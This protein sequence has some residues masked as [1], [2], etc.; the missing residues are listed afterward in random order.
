M[1]DRLV[2]KV[3]SNVLTRKDGSI[4]VTRMSSLTDQIAS[5]TENGKEIIL[6]SSGSVACGRSMVEV[7][8]K[9]DSVDQRQLYSAV[10]QVRL[11]N[12]YY[13]LFR[14]HG[15]RI[16]QVLTMKE[17]FSTRREYLNQKNCMEV[18]LKS[19][20]LPVVNENDTVS[21]TELMFTDNDELSSLVASMMDAKTL[22]ILSNVDGIFDGS[23]AEPG[24]K[25]ISE[26]LPDSD[27]SRYIKE[28]KSSLGRGGM[29]SKFT[30]ARNAAL[31]GIKVI[32]ANGKR[33]NILTDLFTCPEN[34]PHTTFMPAEGMSGIKKWI[35]RSG[36]FAKGAVHINADA[37][38]ALIGN[39]AVSL[40][41][42]GVTEVDG[43]FEEG[44]IIGIFDDK[45]KMIAIGRSSYGSATARKLIGAHD[46]KPIVHYDYLYME[47]KQDGRIQ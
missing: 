9:L 20:V 13:Q 19:G 46:K 14:D 18:M 39:E 4:D 41:M 45:G 30:S 1:K 25:V 21:L 35:A 28:E 12:L 10:G 26:V 7:G 40:L 42:V 6:V 5:L 22:V 17:S 44:D 33:D 27:L 15:I 29:S 34:V 16:G 37:A 3:G 43:D 23:P 32:I 36:G 38:K 2:I 8:H 11:I 24:S 47:G 31:E